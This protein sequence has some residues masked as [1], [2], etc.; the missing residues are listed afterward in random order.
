M[1]E[2]KA[3]EFEDKWH[4]RIIR[5][6]G[7]RYKIP[8]KK[9]LVTAAL[10]EYEDGITIFGIMAEDY[11]FGPDSN[12]HFFTIRIRTEELEECMNDFEIIEA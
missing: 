5:P 8:I 10:Y 1:D 4:R 3:R 7:E 2:N 12:G 9:Y 11:K 6:K